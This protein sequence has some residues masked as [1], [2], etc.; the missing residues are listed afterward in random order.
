MTYTV[1]ITG[2]G[3]NYCCVTVNGQTYTSATTLTVEAGTEISCKC[4]AGNVGQST[5]TENGTLVGTT[6]GSNC[7]HSFEVVSDTTIVLYYKSDYDTS[8]TITYEVV[9]DPL[10]PHDGHNTLIGS[11]AYAIEGG[12]AMANGAVYEIELGMTLVGGVAYEIPFGPSVCTIKITGTG[13]TNVFAATYVKIDGTSYAADA[14]LEVP[15]GTVIECKAGAS[16]YTGG[17]YVN[18]VK[19]IDCGSKYNYTVTKSIN[20]SLSHTSSRPQSAY[21]RITEE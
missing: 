10:A 3:S 18:G 13:S 2:T 19:V 4:R 8:I 20:I 9:T 21:V 6:S 1:K 5:I 11:T 17:V 7:T 12:T 14:T 15:S 16:A